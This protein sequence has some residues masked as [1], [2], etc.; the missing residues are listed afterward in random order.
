MPGFWREPRRRVGRPYPAEQRFVGDDVVRLSAWPGSIGECI[1]EL[2]CFDG[3]D[4]HDRRRQAAV[5]TFVP[6][7]IRPQPDRQAVGDDLGELSG[8][9]VRRLEL[10]GE[11]AAQQ[12]LRPCQ[13]LRGRA[14]GRELGVSVERGQIR[15]GRGGVARSHGGTL[16]IGQENAVPVR[17]GVERRGV[18]GR[19][20]AAGQQGQPGRHDRDPG[21]LLHASILSLVLIEDAGITIPYSIREQVTSVLAHFFRG[22]FEGEM[23]VRGRASARR[24]RCLPE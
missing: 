16:E 5:Q 3:L 9:R 21:D 7:A 10:Q 20:G 15:A 24:S 6:L 1:A 12:A 2:D 8:D 11:L 19:E 18:G 14:F 23:A 13:L 17:R 22:F 4:A